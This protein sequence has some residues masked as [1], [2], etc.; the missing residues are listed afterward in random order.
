[1]SVLLLGNDAYIDDDKP[2]ARREIYVLLRSFQARDQHLKEMETFRDQL[3][4]QNVIQFLPDP[5]SDTVPSY[6]AAMPYEVKKWV[7]TRQEVVNV[8]RFRHPNGLDQHDY[9]KAE[10]IPDRYYVWFRNR[11]QMEK[12]VA[13]LQLFCASRDAPLPH[14]DII[15]TTT[16]ELGGGFGHIMTVPEDVLQWVMGSDEVINVAPDELLELCELSPQAEWSKGREY[17]TKP[18][19][20]VDDRFAELAGLEFFHSP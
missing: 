11:D 7:K 14:V 16:T 17:V 3:P 10:Y 1:M 20:E 15:P 13:E 9:A 18:P 4:G 2:F 19:Q 8:R 12:H 6:H 5:L